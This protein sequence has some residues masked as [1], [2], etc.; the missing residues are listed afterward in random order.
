MRVSVGA[1]FIVLVL[2]GC[3][4][5]LFPQGAWIGLDMQNAT[6]IVTSR[7]TVKEDK[8]FTLSQIYIQKGASSPNK[9]DWTGKW[10]YTS[11]GKPRLT[12]TYLTRQI[13][14]GQT[15]DVSAQNYKLT[16]VVDRVPGQDAFQWSEEFAGG[17]THPSTWTPAVGSLP[18]Q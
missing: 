4:H 17:K 11:S 6:T 9:T 16:G 3:K 7:F 2:C 12:L 13:N 10:E 1:T 15:E 14:E 18:G 5:D 8:T